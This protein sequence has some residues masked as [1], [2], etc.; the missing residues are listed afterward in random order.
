MSKEVIKSILAK[1]PPEQRCPAVTALA[2]DAMKIGCPLWAEE[3]VTLVNEWHRRPNQPPKDAPPL[4]TTEKTEPT[5]Q[6][7]PKK[8]RK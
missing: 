6:P 2:T 1:I 3:L 5:P 7:K 8:K 4:P